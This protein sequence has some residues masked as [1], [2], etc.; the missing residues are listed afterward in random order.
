MLKG[1]DKRKLFITINILCCFLFFIVHVYFVHVHEAWRDEAQA[2]VLVKNSSL[3]EL[4]SLFSSEGHPSLWFLTIFPFVKLGL[5]FSLFSYVS[6]T[7][8]TIALFLFLSFGEL[9][10]WIKIAVMFSSIFFYFNPVISRIYSVLVLLIIM[11]GLVWKKRQDH[12]ILYGIIIALL[13]QSHILMCGLA[14][15]CVVDIV[16]ILCEKNRTKNGYCALFIALFSF[17]L[18]LLELWQ[19]TSGPVAQEV[20]L[21]SVLSQFSV[22]N[23]VNGI[24]SIANHSGTLVRG[25][26]VFLVFGCYFCYVL[27]AV[28]KQKEN[29]YYVNELVV[30]FFACAGYLGVVCF[31]RAALHMQMAICFNMIMFLACWMLYANGGPIIRRCSIC[32]ILLI[33]VVSYSPTFDGIKTDVYGD[34]SKSK[35]MAHYICDTMDDKDIV[36]VE[37]QPTTPAV[38]AYVS[39][40]SGEPQF[41]DISTNGKYKYMQWGIPYNVEHS[42]LEIRDFA[43]NLQNE[44][45][46]KV[47]YLSD[48]LLG[49]EVSFDLIKRCDNDNVWGEKYYLYLIE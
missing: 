15:G 4:F 35:E 16:L 10:Y 39:S 42:E 47:Y 36:I 46:D 13:F 21:K 32:V 6:L 20:S 40:I 33:A 19:R 45:T 28:W 7:L 30:I 43:S 44:E 24:F 26:A 17:L 37:N 23:I 27:Y 11:L 41:V 12:M 48:K 8:V 25:C 5:D 29:L 2:W 31:V 22:T 3:V 14:I 9:P 1:I 34:F 38:Y 49:S 18:M